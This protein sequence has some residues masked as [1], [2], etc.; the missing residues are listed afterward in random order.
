MPDAYPFAGSTSADA[1]AEMELVPMCA[2]QTLAWAVADEEEA[3]EL[4]S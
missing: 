2:G 4:E 3:E 1:E